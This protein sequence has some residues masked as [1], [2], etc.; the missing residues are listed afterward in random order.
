M[1]KLIV[2]KFY[3]SSD[4]MHLVT[5]RI[6]MQKE[7]KSPKQSPKVD[8]NT[9]LNRIKIEEKNETK[10]TFF[11]VTVSIMAISLSFLFLLF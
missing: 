3:T 8:I 11:L 7:N 4:N 10:K 9:L 2:N 5:D 1:V 6:K